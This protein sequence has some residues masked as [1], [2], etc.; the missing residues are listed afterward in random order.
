MMSQ[1]KGKGLQK[2]YKFAKTF[3][4]MKKDPGVFRELLKKEDQFI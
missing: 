4:L 1:W 3:I 2:F